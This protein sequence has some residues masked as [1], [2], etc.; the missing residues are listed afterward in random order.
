MPP[1]STP[2]PASPRSPAS[3]SACAAANRP[4]RHLS[5]DR[6]APHGV[7]GGGPRERRARCEVSDVH[8]HRTRR[9]AHAR[10][11]VRA[12]GRDPLG[13]RVPRRQGHLAPLGLRT[14][15]GGVRIAN[16]RSTNPASS[17]IGYGPLQST[18]GANR[19]EQRRRARDRRGVR[20]RTW[21]PRRSGDDQV[22]NR[23]GASGEAPE[24]IRRRSGCRYRGCRAP[25]GRDPALHRSR[26][27]DNRDRRRHS[28]A[29]HRRRQQRAVFAER[30][31][32]VVERGPTRDDRALTRERHHDRRSPGDLVLAPP[33][34]EQHRLAGAGDDRQLGAG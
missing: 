31:A 2:P 9:R 12:G 7:V 23:R 25:R 14:S 20:G 18:V 29:R 19:A 8:R 26:A 15:A 16:G 3:K 6:P 17:W 22:T 4:K 13:D 30:L 33:H 5:G 1:S 11:L 32:D 24:T 27:R 21:S 10:R 34:R 28:R